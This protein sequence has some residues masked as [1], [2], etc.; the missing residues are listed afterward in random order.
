M[1]RRFKVIAGVAALAAFAACGGSP[2]KS[3]KPTSPAAAPDAKKVDSAT[4]GTIS[5]KAVLE[6]TAPENP[7]INMS[8]DPAC[9]GAN[10]GEVRSETYMVDK[11]GLQNVFVYIKDGLGN[12]YLFDTPMD[13]VKLDQRGCHYI[14][15]VIGVRVGQPLEIVN[16]DNTMHNVHGM[17]QT[18]QEFN[19]GQP[20]PGLKQAVTFTAPEVMIP[21][22]CDVHSWMR[23]YIG[24][25]N[26]PYFAVTG[27]G[28]T[29]TLRDVPAGTYTI[30]AWHEKSGTQT[31]RVTLGAKES[32][33]ITF[34]FKVS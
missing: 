26:H 23:A 13:P 27:S 8:S 3:S 31:Q 29:F 14:P 30:E 10:K 6:G 17:P 5:G 9:S 12:K 34:T 25:V 22:K 1:F 32:K 11:G 18:N 24:V 19:F 4:A 21:F 15:H 2:D 33:E 28:G 7:V 20:V 16:S